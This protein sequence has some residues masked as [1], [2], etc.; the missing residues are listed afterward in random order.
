MRRK[1]SKLL[2]IAGLLV[3]PLSISR[4][5]AAD[6]EPSDGFMVALKGECDPI[7]PSTT[8]FDCGA[9]DCAGWFGTCN[10]GPW[11]PVTY[12]GTG[13]CVGSTGR[14]QQQT[15]NVNT[16]AMVDCKCQSDGVTCAFLQVIGRGSTPKTDCINLH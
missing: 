11:T 1:V 5:V 16:E 7:V 4:V 8:D 14:C 15:V 9:D 10:D 2:V 6:G 3:I 13:T 12:T